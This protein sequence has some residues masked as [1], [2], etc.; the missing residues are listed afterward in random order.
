MK[1]II[2]LVSG[3]GTNL[4]ALLDAEQ[5]G[6]FPEGK[7]TCV[8]SSR[9]DAYALQRAEQFHVKSRVIAKKDFADFSAYTDAMLIAL[10]EEKADLIVLAGFLTILD[11]RIIAA[12]P[13]R[14]INVHPSL[15]PAFCGEGFYG[16]R[17]HEYALQRG[18]KYSGATVHFVNEVADGGP[19]I[20]Q[21]PVAIRDDDTPQT[22]QKRIMEEAEWKLLPEAVRLFCADKLEIVEDKVKLLEQPVLL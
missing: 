21:K 18:V 12:Y 17:V 10:Q 7:I 11:A 13:N 15:I 1:N 3:G 8:I 20:L 5:A 16:M 2:V 19:I 6:S 22:L 14:I 4:Q 9:R